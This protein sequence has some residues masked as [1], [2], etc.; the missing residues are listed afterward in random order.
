[1]PTLQQLKDRAQARL[2]N[3]W[4]N[5]IVPRQIEY[6]SGNQNNGNFWQG[7]YFSNTW[8]QHTNVADDDINADNLAS[9]PTDQNESWVD[10]FPELSGISHPFNFRCDVFNGPEGKGFIARA[11]LYYDGTPYFAEGKYTATVLPQFI[12]TGEGEVTSG[13]WTVPAGNS[14]WLDWGVLATGSDE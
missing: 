1:M 4:T 10:I 12:I 8:P 13:Y 11:E 6:Y 2:T 7:L 9:S 5:Y 3:Y 14:Q